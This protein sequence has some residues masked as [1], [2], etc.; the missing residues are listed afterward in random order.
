VKILW[1][2]KDKYNFKCK[3]NKKEWDI[4]MNNWFKRLKIKK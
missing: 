1:N 3:L 2:Y 4:N